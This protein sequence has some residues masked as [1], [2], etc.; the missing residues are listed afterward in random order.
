[1]TYKDNEKTS[2]SFQLNFYLEQRSEKIAKKRKV[3]KIRLF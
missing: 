3:T 1:M 2:S